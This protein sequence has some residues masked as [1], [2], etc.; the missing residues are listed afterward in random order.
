MIS[1]SSVCRGTFGSPLGIKNATFPKGKHMK[2]DDFQ[3]WRL[4]DKIQAYA[5]RWLLNFS[6]PKKLVTTD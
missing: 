4:W 5:N 2:I 6:P 1:G 3:A